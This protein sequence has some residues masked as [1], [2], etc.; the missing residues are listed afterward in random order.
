MCLQIV[1]DMLTTA[2]NICIGVIDDIIYMGDIV[3]ISYRARMSLNEY[4]V[5]V[6][7]YLIEVA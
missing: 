6:P 1:K 5:D 4:T 7:S 3:R 2:D